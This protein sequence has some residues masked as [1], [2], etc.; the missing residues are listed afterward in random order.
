[1]TRYPFQNKATKILDK[2]QRVIYYKGMENVMTLDQRYKETKGWTASHLVQ[3]AIANFGGD[4]QVSEQQEER[5]KAAE[6]KDSAD[7]FAVRG[8]RPMPIGRALTQKEC[9]GC[10]ILT[11]ERVRVARQYVK[12]GSPFIT[13]ALCVDCQGRT[14]G[15]R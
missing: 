10:N 14:H 5:F 12:K 3:D 2:M 7:S 11:F 4:W 6:L 9:I 13:K 15:I 1:M 8:A